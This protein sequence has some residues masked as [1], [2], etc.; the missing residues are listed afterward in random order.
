MCNGAGAAG[1]DADTAA[2][3]VTAP[4]R[5]ADGVP[6]SHATARGPTCPCPSA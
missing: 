5:S 4:Y 6:V 3:N 1:N 2:D